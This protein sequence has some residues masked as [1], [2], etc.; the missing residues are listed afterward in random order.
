[1]IF[2]TSV[3]VRTYE[4]EPKYG[5]ISITAARLAQWDK[6][7]SAEQQVQTLARPTLRVFR[8]KCRVCNNICKWLDFPVFLDKDDK[9]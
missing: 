5:G 7:R 6:R 4:K 9:P 2:F 1:M 3:V 8:R